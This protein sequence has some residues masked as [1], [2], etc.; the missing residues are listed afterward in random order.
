MSDPFSNHEPSDTSP[1]IAA[2]AITPSDDT[3]LA[4]TIRA[5][6]INV[7]GT[8]SYISS[9]DG[10]TYTTAALPTGTYALF[11]SRIRATGTTATAITGW[12]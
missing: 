1:A 10:A 3:D 8:V 5:I 9:R 6:T 4:V 7:S 11:A 2:Y 12:A